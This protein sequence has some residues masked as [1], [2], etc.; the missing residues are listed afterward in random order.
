MFR[1]CAAFRFACG[2]QFVMPEVVHEGHTP[3]ADGVNFSVGGVPLAFAPRRDG[4]P[5]LDGAYRAHLGLD[6]LDMAALY[7]AGADLPGGS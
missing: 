5:L 4:A 2:R 7:G 1:R 6:A 3:R